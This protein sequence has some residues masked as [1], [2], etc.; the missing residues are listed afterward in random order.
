MVYQL[1]NPGN[2]FTPLPYGLASAVTWLIPEGSHWEGGIQWDDTC[3]QALSTVSPC[4]TGAVLDAPAKAAT[5]DRSFRAARAFTVYSEVDCSAPGF[6][7]RAEELAAQGL[8]AS[9]AHAMERVFQTGTAGTIPN[10]IYPNLTTTGTVTDTT[11]APPFS[12]LLQPSAVVVS[13]ACLDVVEGVGR[14]ESA[15]SGTGFDGST[16]YP[17]GIATIHVPL[18]LASAFQAQYQLIKDG[19]RLR[20]AAG[21]LVVIGSGYD[22]TIG[23]N[24]AAAPSGCGWVYA[25]G[26]VFGYQSPMRRTGNRA[27]SFDRT[28]NTLK[29]I[30][31]R[32][33]VLGYACCRAAVLVTLGGEPAGTF[34]TSS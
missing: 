25:T 32:T 13:G 18:R 11:T 15:I 34:G 6:W 17:G 23:P 28:E 29:E 8:T 3:G 30:V 27:E 19:P 21:N 9:E 24:G 26:P 1:V 12:F 16:C 2:T 10:I 22:E 7:D 4:I 14:L 31:E 33:F 20:T 5:W